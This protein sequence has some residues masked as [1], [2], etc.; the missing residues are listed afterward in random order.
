VAELQAALTDAAGKQEEAALA[1]HKAELAARHA[2]EERDAAV[3][4]ADSRQREIDRMAGACREVWGGG[5]GGSSGAG[6]LPRRACLP[7]SLV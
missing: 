5:G 6:G 7:S 4:R 2:A 1:S 3:A